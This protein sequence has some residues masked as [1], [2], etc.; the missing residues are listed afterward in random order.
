MMKQIYGLGKVE[1]GKLSL[2]NEQI[3]KEELKS[4]SGDVVVLVKEGRPKRSTQQNKYY[5]SVICRIISEHTGYT[6]EEVHEF[7]KET[8]LTDRKLITIGKDEREIEKATTTRLSTKEFEEYCENIR[9]HASVELNLNIP[10]PNEGNED[11]NN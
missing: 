1:K 3:F 10:E 4:L 5:W 8:F 11:E 2:N 7:Y 6:P 9:R